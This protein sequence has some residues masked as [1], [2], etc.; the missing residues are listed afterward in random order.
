MAICTAADEP[1]EPDTESAR[2]PP[3]PGYLDGS[4]AR[5][6]TTSRRAIRARCLYCAGSWAGVA[7]CD[8]T[9]CHL[10]PFYRTGGPQKLRTTRDRLSGVGDEPRGP[11]LKKKGQYCR[12]GRGNGT[13]VKP[14]ATR[15]IR[16]H[17]LWCC[18]NSSYEVSLC[19]EPSCPLYR[20]RFG[21]RPETRARRRSAK[22]D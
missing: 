7:R 13:E 17:C 5:K 9:D 22:E 14:S 3:L 10:Y 1:D 19:V 16:Q 8:V 21:V 20:W 18:G 2:L 12:R 15:A 11:S 6:A 4:L